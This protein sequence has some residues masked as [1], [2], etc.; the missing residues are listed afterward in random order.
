MTKMCSRAAVKGGQEVAA[1]HERTCNLKENCAKTG[2][3]VFTADGKFIAFDDAGNSVA[4]KALEAST[5]KDDMKV[6]VTGEIQG[7]SM[8][9]AD[10]KLAQ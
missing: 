2:F 8:K 5:R 6:T 10:L 9:V 4:R 7:D 1:K 3:G